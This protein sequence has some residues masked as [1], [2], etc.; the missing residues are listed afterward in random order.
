MAAHASSRCETWL[1]CLGRSL[2]KHRRPAAL[3]WSRL[4]LATGRPWRHRHGDHLQRL[5]R[6]V[7]AELECGP[8]GNRETDTGPQVRCRGL[9][10]LLMAPHP[11]HAADD[12]PDLLNRG[13]GDGLRDL[14]G[15]KLEVGKATETAELA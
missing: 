7:R 2:P 1:C 15:L 10:A 11:S 13:M 14:D 8:E 12:V 5:V 9:V 6:A 4:L 3:L